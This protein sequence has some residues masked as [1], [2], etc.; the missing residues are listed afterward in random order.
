MME[1]DTFSQIRLWCPRPFGTYS[2]NKLCSVAAG[3]L[4]K[5]GGRG[6]GRDDDAAGCTPMEAVMREGA[7]EVVVSQNTPPILDPPP[8]PPDNQ[9]EDGR[10][11]LDTWYVIKPGNTKEKI[12]FFVAHQCSGAAL[13][14]PNTMKV[15]G[16]WGSDCTKAKR[17]RRCSYTP[18][19][20]PPTTPAG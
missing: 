16:R 3:D 18:P 17:R 12:A 15:K 9:V 1:R 14:R 6:G 10:V 20:P 8:V 19:A 13:L 11:L 4:L 2:Q 7:E 5:G